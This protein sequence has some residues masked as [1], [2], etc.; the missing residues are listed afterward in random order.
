M[1]GVDVESCLVEV[2]KL[3]LQQ[4]DVLLI[5]CPDRIAFDEVSRL[6]ESLRAM[7]PHGVGIAYVNH[8]MVLTHCSVPEVLAMYEKST[9]LQSGTHHEH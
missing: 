5:K 9:A 3:S 4:G 2:S 7:V 8:E 6:H 1:S